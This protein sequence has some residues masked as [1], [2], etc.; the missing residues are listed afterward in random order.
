MPG[1][2]SAVRTVALA[3]ACVLACTVAAFAQ[4]WN[5]QVSNPGPDGA[6]V[7]GSSHVVLSGRDVSL[8]YSVKTH[9]RDVSL[10]SCRAHL[11]D[12][13]DVRSVKNASGTFLFLYL[14]AG[15]VANCGAAGNQQVAIVP[16]ADDAAARS[17]LT[18][19]QHACCS[20]AAVP[21]SPR[22]ATTGAP[23]KGFVP[24]ADW[25]ETDGIFAFLR[26]RNR[27]ALPLT[28]SDGEILNCRDIAGGCGRF[29]AP[30][31]TVLPGTVS[32]V[33]TVVSNSSQGGSFSFRYEARSDAG[34]FSASG[35]STKRTADTSGLMV[36]DE[37]RSAEALAV[38]QMTAPRP[39]GTHAPPSYTGPRLTHRGS[40][41][42]AVGKRGT[43]MVRVHVDAK[44]RPENASIVSIDNR[45]LVAAALET[46]VSST[47]A[48][49][50]R[51]GRATDADYIATFRFDGSDPAQASIPSWRRSPL[52]APLPTAAASP[53]AVAPS[54]AASP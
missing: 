21:A 26:V 43:A 35:R 31:I 25:V 30:T 8:S 48:P 46:A 12:V 37:M 10:T 54:P 23:A 50:M 3:I 11:G 39:N 38:A 28:V 45:E 18:A 24:P 19:L 22:A 2:S 9:D 44:G 27:S 16:V 52:P 34:E 49:A 4:S 1:F 42:L 6:A 47:Y 15:R 53:A 5:W 13:S 51:D 7:P 17:A 20:V 40:S 29:A 32:T 41:R 14:K 36:P 33:A